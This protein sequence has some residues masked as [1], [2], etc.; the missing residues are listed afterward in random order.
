MTSGFLER[1]QDEIENQIEGARKGE[2]SR[3]LKA[4]RGIL[5]GR[6]QSNVRAARPTPLANYDSFSLFQSQAAAF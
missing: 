1:D 4:R 2:R 3:N 5:P 6:I